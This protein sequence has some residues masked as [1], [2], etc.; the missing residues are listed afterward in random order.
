MR[1][2][3]EKSGYRYKGED[4]AGVKN[5]RVNRREKVSSFSLGQ[6]LVKQNLKNLKRREQQHNRVVGGREA[7]GSREKIEFC[8]L[9][10]RFTKKE[11]MKLKEEELETW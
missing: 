4:C 8:I 5:D 2:K 10:L 11:M 3:E 9:G 1:V 6:V 7:D